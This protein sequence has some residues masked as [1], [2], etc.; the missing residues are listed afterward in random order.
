MEC[1]ALLP[2]RWIIYFSPPEGLYH[3]H[4]RFVS[5]LI[6]MFPNALSSPERWG[7]Y[8][9]FGLAY[10]EA[11]SIRQGNLRRPEEFV[12][13]YGMFGPATKTLDNIFQST[14]GTLS[15][16]RKICFRFDLYVSECIVIP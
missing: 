12:I 3:L 5:V 4:G 16:A 1:S 6:C 10:P 8:R 11:F 15:F 13:H 7:C 14:R 2:R 9:C